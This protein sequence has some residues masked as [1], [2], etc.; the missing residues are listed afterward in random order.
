LSLI[1]RV[2]DGRCEIIPKARIDRDRGEWN[3]RFGSRGRR[4]VRASLYP[5][6]TYTLTLTCAARLEWKPPD[7]GPATGEVLGW[8]RTYYPGTA[9]QASAG[10]SRGAQAR[11][12]ACVFPGGIDDI[13]EPGAEAWPD[14][15][16]NFR[17]EYVYRG[18]YRRDQV[19][20]QSGSAYY[21][22]AVRLGETEIA[23]AM[24]LSNI[25]NFGV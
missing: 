17:L 8:A 5:G 19:P 13:Y 23:P 21:L 12:C 25:V 1:A 15:G 4:Q 2:V 11:R 7:P 18:A 20:Q 16:G 14:A 10:K 22:D 6:L 3:S 9:I 24:Q